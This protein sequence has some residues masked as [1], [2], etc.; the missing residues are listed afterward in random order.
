MKLSVGPCVVPTRSQSIALGEERLSQ[1]EYLK[2]KAAEI[3]GVFE[4]V[5]DAASRAIS[6]YAPPKIDLA[7]SKDSFNVIAVHNQRVRSGNQRFSDDQVLQKEPAI[8]RVRAQAPGGKL[9]TYYIARVSP[10]SPSLPGLDTLFVSYRAPVGRLASIDAG[11]FISL[12]IGDFE[13]VERALLRPINDGAWD[14]RDSVVETTEFGPLTVQSLRKLLAKE[15]IEEDLDALAKLLREDAAAE[16]VREGLRRSVV[17]KMALR[18]QPVLDKFQDDIFRLPLSNQLLILGP[19]GTGKTTT[20]IRRL[21]QKLDMNHLDEGE[22]ALVQRSEITS[23]LVHAQSWLM[24]T[25][26][27]LLKQYV[28]EAFA[29]EGIA[30]SEQRITTWADHRRELA[31]GTLPILRTNSG[32]GIFVLKEGIETFLPDASSNLIDWFDDFDRWQRERTFVQF[33]QAADELSRENDRSLAK[34]GERAVD[35]LVRFDAARLEELTIVLTTGAKELQELIAVLKGRTDRRIDEALN[36]QVNRNR[37]FLDEFALFLGSM[38]DVSD[39]AV[40]DVEDAETE[41]EE[42]GAAPSTTRGFAVAQY[43]RFARGQARAS[44]RRRAMGKDS[45]LGKIGEWVGDRGLSEAVRAEVGTSLLVQARVRRLASPIRRMLNGTPRRYREFR[46]LRQSEARWYKTA[47]FNPTDIGPLEVDAV[48]LAMLR[49]A[50]PLMRRLDAGT[51]QDG[52]EWGIARALRN[53]RRN[54]VLVD[55]TTDFSPIQLACM[56]ALVHPATRSFF[57][58][59]DFNQRLTRWGSRDLS[60]VEWAIRGISKKTINVSYRQTKELNELARSLAKVS[61]ADSEVVL[62]DRVDNTGV[63]PVLGEDKKAGAVVEWLAGRIKEIETFTNQLPSIAVLVSDESDVLPLAEALNA[64][65]ANVNIRVVPYLNGQAIGQEND[66]RVFDIQHIKGLEF[67]AVFFVGVDLLANRHPELFD[68][69]LYVGTTRA[70]TYLGM[71]CEK[72]LPAALEFTRQHFT[73]HW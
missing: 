51:A 41:D 36:I 9:I 33:H 62:P 60:Q 4:A 57:A 49:L 50:A 65:L 24:F 31:R 37:G 72:R 35:A 15:E 5:A 25:P 2:A 29:R 22:K 1:S 10:P 61:G 16:N 69:Y 20:L 48:L 44:A 11:E 28:K 47:G 8:A 3:L 68:K 6:N 39:A 42:E 71:T 13:V 64:A 46:R 70:A 18:D 12:P 26:T 63:R 34:M 14:S 55:E 56:S 7:G 67:E 32:S 38:R 73:Q 43:R 27:D 66:V 30:A 53:I 19:P 54:Q 23:G 21:G 59:G 58:C 52:P 40:D 45:V 17:T